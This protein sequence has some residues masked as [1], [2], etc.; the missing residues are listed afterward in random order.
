MM[1]HRP[2]A[3]LVAVAAA[4]GTVCALAAASAAIAANPPWSKNNPPVP[5]AFTN[6][7]PGLASIVLTNGNVPGTFVIWKGQFNSKIQYKFKIDGSPWSKTA[8]IPVA[9][10]T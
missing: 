3:G 2:K 4:A 9:E 8:T 1:L 10:T 7:T 6:A 5:G